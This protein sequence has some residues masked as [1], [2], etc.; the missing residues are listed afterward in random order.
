MGGLL[1]LLPW[2]GEG[3]RVLLQR[4]QGLPPA[5]PSSGAGSGRLQ[6]ARTTAGR[7]SS[8]TSGAAHVEEQ[9]G[10]AGDSSEGRVTCPRTWG[11]KRWGSRPLVRARQYLSTV[12]LSAG[13][14]ASRTG[15]WV[16]A[17]VELGRGIGRVALGGAPGQANFGRSAG[18]QGIG[19]ACGDG[20][21]GH[22]ARFISTAGLRSRARID[23]LGRYFMGWMEEVKERGCGKVWAAGK[24]ESVG[25]ELG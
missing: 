7:G 1:A 12:R 9:R 21:H 2:R 16:V 5:T 25:V 8:L 18:E 3:G 24:L 23:E 19:G 10:L 11:S 6:S 22:D 20:V 13:D 14:G 15:H 4:A 17:W